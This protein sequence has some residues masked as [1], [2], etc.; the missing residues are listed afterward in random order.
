M[1]NDHYIQFWTHPEILTVFWIGIVLFYEG[2]FVFLPCEIKILCAFGEFCI[3]D[4]VFDV[5]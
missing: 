5:G 3:H 2:M 4:F 1:A